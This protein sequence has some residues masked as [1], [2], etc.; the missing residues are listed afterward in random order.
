MRNVLLPVLVILSGC[1]AKIDEALVEQVKADVIS[2]LRD[3]ESSKFRNIS[4]V[5]ENFA[6]ERVLTVCGELNSKNGYGAY[7]GYAP[8]S[9][10]SSQEGSPIAR[11]FPQ[12]GG[13]VRNNS[14]F[15]QALCDSEGNAKSPRDALKALR[16]A[17]PEGLD[18]TQS[19]TTFTK[20]EIEAMSPSAPVS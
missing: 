3:P 13:G 17:F 7:V 12:R 14:K 11:F 6:D 19:K 20:E 15:Y 16:I 9:G 10:I 1:T 18:G 2:D 4:Y 5:G 8:F